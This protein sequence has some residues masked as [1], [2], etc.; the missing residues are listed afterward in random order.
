MNTS[1]NDYVPIK[2]FQLMRFKGEQY[3]KLGGLLAAP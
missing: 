2:Q 3:E 1:P